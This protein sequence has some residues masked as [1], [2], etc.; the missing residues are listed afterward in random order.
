MAL[1]TDRIYE[2]LDPKE[3]P[4]PPPT[5]KR[6]TL[7]RSKTIGPTTASRFTN[8]SNGVY[9]VPRSVMSTTP[10]ISHIPPAVPPRNRNCSEGEVTLAGSPNDRFLRW[11]R[12]MGRVGRGESG[13]Q[14]KG[15]KGKKWGREEGRERERKRE[16]EGEKQHCMYKRNLMCNFL[17]LLQRRVFRVP[18]WQRV[19]STKV[20]QYL[21]EIKPPYIWF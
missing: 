3:P 8:G 2:V 14:G 4:K 21:I 7:T 5:A 6:P 11:E 12:E 9:A 10:L 13:T 20:Q 1:E 18:Q 19:L 16:R 15:W 17:F